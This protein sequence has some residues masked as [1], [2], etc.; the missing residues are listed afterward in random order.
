MVS[1][2]NKD[3]YVVHLPRIDEVVPEVDDLLNVSLEHEDAYNAWCN[4]RIRDAIRAQ[5]LAGYPAM[6]YTQYPFDDEDTMDLVGLDSD[7]HVVVLDE[8]GTPLRY[9][10]AT[11]ETAGFNTEPEDWGSVTL[12]FVNPVEGGDPVGDLA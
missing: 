8:R 9:A 6:V 10:A 11:P 2:V 7:G 4:N 3:I 5:S 1:P 12:S